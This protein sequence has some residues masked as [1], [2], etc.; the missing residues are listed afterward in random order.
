MTAR[1]LPKKLIDKRLKA[2]LSWKINAKQTELSRTFTTPNFISGLA[3]TAKV[4][5]LAEV[6]GHHPDVELSYG[7][8][9]VS[10]TTHDAKGLTTKDFELAEKIDSLRV[11]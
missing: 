11:G 10:L 7:H 4:A 9:K 5:V 1:P 8:V 2:L 6:V 3:F